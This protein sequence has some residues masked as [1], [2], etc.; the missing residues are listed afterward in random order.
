[1][2][3][4][5]QVNELNETKRYLWEAICS[6]LPL[7]KLQRIKANE[8][9]K[10]ISLISILGLK[11]WITC[12][13]FA[14]WRVIPLY[15]NVCLIHT[16]TTNHEIFNCAANETPVVTAL[17]SGVKIEQSR[18]YKTL[19]LQSFLEDF[20][21]SFTDSLVKPH[22]PEWIPKA[23]LHFISWNSSRALSGLTYNIVYIELR[24]Y[25]QP[26]SALKF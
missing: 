6:S 5:N 19:D 20:Q 8:L 4:T 13:V 10:R 12:V 9:C 3:A 22:A 2:V 14:T 24:R 11:T 16:I 1:M 23:L 26:G 25:S 18:M 21:A 7:V 15:V 17:A